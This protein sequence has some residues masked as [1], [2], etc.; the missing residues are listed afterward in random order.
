MKKFIYSCFALSVLLFSSCKST[1]VDLTQQYVL[2][3][4]YDANYA[5]GSHF[6][7]T[8]ICSDGSVCHYSVHNEVSEWRSTDSLGYISEEDMT[9]NLHLMMKDESS[10]GSSDISK[11][12]AKIYKASKGELSDPL[13]A[14]ADMG[15]SKQVAYL[16]DYRRK[17]YK[18]ILISQ[19]GDVV[20]E[21]ESTSAKE[22]STWLTEL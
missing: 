12:S 8:L 2:F 14:G 18:E 3:G 21:N 9:F 13:D 15:M 17:V 4:L 19:W 10:I 7:A 22:I 5:W 1:N 6:G 11:Y 20:I 16:Y